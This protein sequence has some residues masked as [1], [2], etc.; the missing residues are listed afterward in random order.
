MNAV[1][2]TNELMNELR[3]APSF[4]Q[5]AEANEEGFFAEDTTCPF[6]GA[7]LPRGASFCTACMRPLTERLTIPAKKRRISRR[8]RVL[9]YVLGVILFLA[10]AGVLCFFLL[11][12]SEEQ[13]LSLE[14][15]SVSEFRRLAAGAS[16]EE[17]RQ[18]WS[19]EAFT[20][21]MQEGKFSIYETNADFLEEP[22]RIA[23]SDDGKCLFA[24][25][26]GFLPEDTEKAGKLAE[27]LFSAVYRYYPENL[28]EILR[29]DDY[30]TRMDGPDTALLAFTAIASVD[31][32]S[33]A[34]IMESGRIVADRY[35]NASG[36][37]VWGTTSRGR[38]SIFILFGEEMP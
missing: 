31:L 15:P 23:F 17:M 38:R 22:L 24:A 8:T 26:C 36:A 20:R 7:L 4:G 35:E 32:P 34:E 1:K 21:K 29:K 3:E 2:N 12:P 5:Y 27:S 6:C 28:A 19:Q 16:E 30:F 9:Y 13:K 14:I 18:I 37:R 25:I 33:D 11:R 10:A